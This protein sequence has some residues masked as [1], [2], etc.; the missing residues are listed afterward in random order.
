MCTKTLCSQ[1]EKSIFASWTARKKNP[2]G[3][4]RRKIERANATSRWRQSNGVRHS[5]LATATMSISSSKSRLGT[6]HVNGTWQR[7]KAE[8]A[9][10]HQRQRRLGTNWLRW[11]HTHLRLLC[12]SLWYR[13]PSSSFLLDLAC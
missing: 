10:D 3:Q 4:L 5:G 6:T 12:S 8:R 2:T 13:S 9:G 7:C 11:Q 1:P